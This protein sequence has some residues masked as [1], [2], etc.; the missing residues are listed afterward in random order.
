MYQTQ[1]Y[2]NPSS[3]R[4]GDLSNSSLS[5]RLAS[6]GQ[7]KERM[8]ECCKYS[9]GLSPVFRLSHQCTEIQT[10]ACDKIQVAGPHLG[11]AIPYVIP[12]SHQ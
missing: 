11:T 9:T 7:F 5:G 6:V 12:T 2:S 1:G 3:Q 8:S 4:Q 10:G